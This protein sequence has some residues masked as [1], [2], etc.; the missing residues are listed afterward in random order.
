MTGQR[1]LS[2]PCCFICLHNKQAQSAVHHVCCPDESVCETVLLDA[3]F[4][5]MNQRSVDL[6]LGNVC[7]AVC[8]VP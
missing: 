6:S 2:L 3:M 7:A 1:A 5:D 4:A 8:Y